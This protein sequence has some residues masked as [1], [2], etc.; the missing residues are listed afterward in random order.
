MLVLL[1]RAQAMRRQRKRAKPSQLLACKGREERDL[2]RKAWGETRSP[3][4]P[5]ECTRS[6]KSELSPP[7]RIKKKNS[8]CQLLLS[9]R[10]YDL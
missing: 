10:L 9:M 8:D 6:P 4:K 2:K 1:L 3:L 5:S 7:T